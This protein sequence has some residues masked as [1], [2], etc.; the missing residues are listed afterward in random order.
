[1]AILGINH[2]DRPTP[3]KTCTLRRGTPDRLEVR[4]RP[5]AEE[6]RTQRADERSVLRFFRRLGCL[7]LKTVRPD[8]SNDANFFPGMSHKWGLSFDINSEPGPNGRSA[9]SLCW[10]GLFNTYFW[11]DPTR[12]VTG[13]IM[14]QLLPFADGEVMK[15]YAAFESGLYEAL[16][17]A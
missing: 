11:L 2:E 5:V 1:M 6:T 8:L 15:L 3:D 7:P 4:Y 13:T 14:T 12:K 9:G 10:A 16:K 17:S